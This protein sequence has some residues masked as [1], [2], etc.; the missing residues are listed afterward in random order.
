VPPD[1][2][3]QSMNDASSV[4]KLAIECEGCGRVESSERSFTRL[5]SSR[6]NRSNGAVDLLDTLGTLIRFSRQRQEANRSESSETRRFLSF[7]F[8]ENDAFFSQCPQ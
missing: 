6:V 3:N 7:S 4:V 5:S 1:C 8:L 2:L